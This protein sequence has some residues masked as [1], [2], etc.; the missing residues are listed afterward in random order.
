MMGLIK[1]WYHETLRKHVKQVL[2]PQFWSEISEFDT[3]K[4][5]LSPQ[6]LL[7]WT[8]AALTK[9]FGRLDKCMECH[10]RIAAGLQD[11]LVRH[12]PDRP[13]NVRRDVSA[14][15]ALTRMAHALIFGSTSTSTTL[16]HMLQ[17]HL[18]EQFARVSWDDRQQQRQLASERSEEES[19][20]ESSEEEEDGGDGSDSTA[21]G[22]PASK[23]A[24]E[25]IDALAGAMYRLRIAPLLVEIG[26]QML[27]SQI[28]LR[29][30]KTASDKFEDCVLRKLQ[31]WSDRVVLPWLAQIVCAGE[32]DPLYE[33]WRSRVDFHLYETL[34]NL[35]IAE[36]FEIICEYPDSS[37]A[38]EDLKACLQRTRQHHELIV[39]LKTSIC[40]RLLI[41]GPLTDMIIATFI[42]T[43]KALRYLD[44]ALPSGVSLAAVSAPIKE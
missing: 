35:R 38:L 44:P 7:T 11:I 40:K 37:P 21:T 16:Q 30:H 36:L 34:A 14:K 28:Y 26:T 39:S 42:S 25:S 9:A 6:Q 8:S 4:G 41:P 31:T 33:Q 22:L 19:E 12:S 5:A 10:H 24:P 17:S 20:E 23:Q 27:F 32:G 3:R 1:A 15:E 43:V 13:S 18:Q 2:Q 29:I